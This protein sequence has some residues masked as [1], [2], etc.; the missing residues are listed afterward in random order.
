M[1][2]WVESTVGRGEIARDEQSCFPNIVF[3]R[4]VLQTRKTQGFFGK[5]LKTRSNIQ[6]SCLSDKNGYHLLFIVYDTG[7]M[8]GMCIGDPSLAPHCLARYLAV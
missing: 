6:Y 2:K 5:E 8:T 4:L 1:T 3:K 7:T